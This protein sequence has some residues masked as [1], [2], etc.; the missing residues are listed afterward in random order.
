MLYRFGLG[1]SFS[2]GYFDHVVDK[3]KQIVC[4]SNAKDMRSGEWCGWDIIRY[5]YSFNDRTHDE[6]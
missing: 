2:V 5:K 4:M 3:K 1:V 6:T